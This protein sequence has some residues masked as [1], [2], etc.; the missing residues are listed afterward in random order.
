[1]SAIRFRNRI[2]YGIKPLLPSGFRLSLRRWFTQK[3]R[4]QVRHLWPVAPGSE[5]RPSN[6]SGWPHGK[7]F[8]FILTHDVEGR[9]GLERCRQMM[10]LEMRLGFRSSINFIP[11]AL[12]YTVP[13][14]LREELVQNGFELECTTFIMMANFTGHGVNS[15]KKRPVSTTI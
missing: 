3:K 15:P 5:Q 2:Y 7:K 11:E 14:E 4:E 1:M 9:K 6:W 13:V 10:Q 12:D 8:A